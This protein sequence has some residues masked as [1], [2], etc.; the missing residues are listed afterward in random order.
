MYSPGTLKD[1]NMISA[2][3]SRFSGVFRGGSVCEER[4]AHT[5]AHA[6][7][8]LKMKRQG[9]G[10]VGSCAHLHEAVLENDAFERRLTRRVFS[11]YG[12]FF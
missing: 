1:S 4:T 9:G 12:T 6:R 2:V 3:Y 5:H 7:V 11:I 8:I 10:E